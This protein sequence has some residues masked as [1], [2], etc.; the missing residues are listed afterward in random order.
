MKKIAYKVGDEVRVKK[1]DQAPWGAEYT[2]V[3]EKINDDNTL[4]IR[5]V[6]TET[7]NTSQPARLLAV[8]MATGR[9]DLR[10]QQRRVGD[11]KGMGESAGDVGGPEIKDEY[12]NSSWAPKG[13]PGQDVKNQQ[14]NF[15]KQATSYI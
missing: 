12:P 11:P 2:G 3:I 15:Y 1:N 14:S 5:D 6:Y 4:D 10:I 7:L 9:E 13:H 8:P